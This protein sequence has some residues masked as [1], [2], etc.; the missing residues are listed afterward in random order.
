MSPR[1]LHA[2]RGSGH[3]PQALGR[4]WIVF[5]LAIKSLLRSGLIG[6][7]SHGADRVF[8]PAA[9]CLA[10]LGAARFLTSFRNLDRTREFW[11]QIKINQ[12]HRRAVPG[13]SLAIPIAALVRVALAKRV[14]QTPLATVLFAAVCAVAVA[15]YFLTPFLPE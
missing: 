1:Y 3:L 2:H 15:T 12:Q 4:S 10:V 5:F 7:R 14:S 13:I 6:P 8:F 11:R 9:S